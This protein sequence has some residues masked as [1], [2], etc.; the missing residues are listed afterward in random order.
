MHIIKSIHI[1]KF[2][3]FHGLD[4]PTDKN[5]VAIAG[6]NG[7]QK[8]TLLGML[9]QS[10]TMSKKPF[11]LWR[12]IDGESFK[13]DMRDKFK[14]SEKHDKIGEHAWTISLDSSIDAR[15]KFSV[16]SYP[17]NDDDTPFFLRFWNDDNSRRKGTGFPQCP[18][19]FLSLKRLLPLGELTHLDDAEVQWDDEE[20]YFYKYWHN[21]ILILLDD[22]NSIH[23]L[24]EKGT[25]VSLGPETGVA[26]ATTISAGQDNIGKIILAILSFRRLKNNYPNE[27]AGGLIFIDEIESTLYPASQIRL[28][29]FMLKMAKE[30]N[31]Q[32]FFTTHS[33]TMLEYLT[34]DEAARNGETALVYLKK[35][36]PNILAPV[37]P[38]WSAIL[39]DLTLNMEDTSINNK[40]ETFAEDE[41]AFEFLDALLP[42]KIRR[43]ITK[44]R[45]C[46]LGFNEYAKLQKQRIHE[47]ATNVIVLD[48][49][50]FRGEKKLSNAV[51]KKYKNWL[52]LPGTTFPEQGLYDFLWSL[53]ENPDAWDSSLG[54]FS[55]QVCF[56]YQTTY[57]RDKDQIKR[58]YQSISVKFRKMLLKKYFSAHQQEM[59]Q[60]RVDF[61]AAYNHVVRF[62]GLPEI[63]I[64]E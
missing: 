13:T 6:Q 17:R 30:L 62:H 42:S 34:S 21:H 53:K 60:F 63:S 64:K 10:V 26:D 46:T 50:A 57:T 25:K 2:R 28:L 40:V 43:L 15:E 37:H 8:T 54:G 52:A 5:V 45:Q 51:I 12:T 24:S 3:A 61:C 19:I 33:L 20:A 49:D 58:W 18:A 29:K 32:F 7:T 4:I 48:G 35:H 39:K 36:G 47:L 56:Q 44:Q 59:Q 11:S 38:T 22:I 16:R 14:F 23:T 31:L 27:Y 55:S 9:A 1:D 41:V